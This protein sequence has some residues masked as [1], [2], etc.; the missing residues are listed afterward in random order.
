MKLR[1][2]GKAVNIADIFIGKVQNIDINNERFS[3][4]SIKGDE[5]I[6]SKDF[7]EGVERQ[8]YNISNIS[9][10]T[11]GDI[12]S[13]NSMGGINN[14]YRINSYQNTLLF[15]ER[16]NSNCLMCSQ[17]PKDKD[18]TK[19]WYHIHSKT[20]PLIPKD[21]FEIGISGGEPTIL[22]DNFF[23]LVQQITDELPNTSVHVLTNGRN[24]AKNHLAEKMGKI[25]N[26]NL[27]L[28]IPLYSDYYQQHDYIVQAKHAFSQ[29]I[30]GLHN[31]NRYNV[32]LEL[33]IV[34]HKQTINRLQ[35]LSEYI[36]K[37]LPF[38]EHVTF[39]GLEHIGYTPHNIDKLWIDPNEYKDKL[40]DAVLYLANK[41]MKVSI[42]NTQLCL[43]NEN[44]WRYARKSISDWKNEYLP[45]C[46]LCIK[47]DDCAG[48]F[49]WN[50][51]KSK[52]YVNP[53]IGY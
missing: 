31:L 13:V 52:H 8:V 9:D 15:T 28:G 43:L 45:E 27:M 6:I 38:I 1:T 42:Y 12:V 10:F 17:P 11:E 4:L 53:I 5:I 24:F 21:C 2:K 40:E 14:L 41:G 3:I 50:L 51:D 16:C 26:P 19:T 36:Y 30:L 37:N 39:M 20:I 49:R 33:R 34:L 46:N 23:R 7:L 18:D 29:T 47:K 25:N 48:F 44:S 22:G 35:K 32:R